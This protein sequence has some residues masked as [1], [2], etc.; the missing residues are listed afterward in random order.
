[1][2]SQLSQQKPDAELQA[3]FRQ[4]LPQRLRTLL[5]RA[6]AQC[7]SGWDCNVLRTLHDE[8]AQL[9]GACGRYGLLE[10]GER[11]LALESA[12][13]PAVSANQVP[14]AAATTGIDAL[15][16]SLRPH[17]QQ[18][19]RGPGLPAWMQDPPP[20]AGR[21]P[22]PRC[23]TPPPGYWLQLGITDAAGVATGTAAN[24]A[25]AP[26]PDMPVPDHP[27]G[28]RVRII[29]DDDPLIN[30]LLLRLDQQGC[31]VALLDHM[32]G[33]LEQLQGAP[34]DLIIL[35]ADAGMPLER[36]ASALRESRRDPAHRVHLLV[37]LRETDVE[38]RLRALRAGAD[39]C[40]ALPATP[41]ETVGAAL[42]LAMVDEESPYRILIVDDDAPQ[43]LF[44]QAILR[45]AG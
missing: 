34:P 23:D 13:A 43:A 15:L 25:P 5:R 33:L 10:T 44:A 14:D 4:H 1:M 3:A 38:L 24:E 22:F 20:I 16:D 45:R 28:P 29:N 17:L 11:L 27:R 39:R 12:L 32:Q 8:I 19:S 18:A 6:R 21:A 9:A 35:V 26:Q 7:R 36:L 37:L 41:G 40:I 2:A 31:D 42:E 30:E